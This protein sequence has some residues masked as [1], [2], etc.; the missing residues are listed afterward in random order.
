VIAT[1][2][3]RDRRELSL[4]QPRVNAARS[5]RENEGEPE[6]WPINRASGY[7]AQT[8][9][10]VWPKTAGADDVIGEVE[11]EQHSREQQTGSKSL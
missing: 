2:V 4:D 7:R 1:A 9:C 3:A 11:H 8:Q 5:Q 6:E 10:S